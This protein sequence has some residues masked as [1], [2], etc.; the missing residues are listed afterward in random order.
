[1]FY[2]LFFLGTG[3]L[4]NI[5]EQRKKKHSH[6]MF[7]N[8]IENKRKEQSRAFTEIITWKEKM[9]DRI[10]MPM[11]G[12]RYDWNVNF[13]IN[14]S[15]RDPVTQYEMLE[16]DNA[17]PCTSSK[18]HCSFFPHPLK[19]CDFSECVKYNVKTAFNTFHIVSQG[20]SRIWVI[21]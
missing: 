14:M 3:G 7:W 13:I 8:G 15:W 18:H 5:C 4:L 20:I 6:S 2:L 16:N 11:P 9:P 10:K 21:I 1:M 19:Q 17:V 12:I